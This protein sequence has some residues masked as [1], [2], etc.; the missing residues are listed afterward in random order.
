MSLSL[1]NQ[2]N[3]NYLEDLWGEI[4]PG[5]AFGGTT[6]EDVDFEVNDGG[7][8]EH[9]AFITTEQFDTVVN[10]YA[11]AKSLDLFVKEVPFGIYESDTKDFE[12]DELHDLVVAAHKDC[13]QGK[14]VLVRCQAGMNRSGLVMALMLIREG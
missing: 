11:F 9:W 4:L 12:G 8:F 3:V 1:H 5:L 10:M 14:R 13:R 2:Y 6:N 7:R